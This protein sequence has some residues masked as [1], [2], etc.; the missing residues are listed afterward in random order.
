[1]SGSNSSLVRTSFNPSQQL[2][3]CVVA[4]PLV[5]CLSRLGEL[6]RLGDSLFYRADHVER[7]LREMV[8]VSGAQTF[9]PLDCV[10]NGD[11]FA[12]RAREDLRNVER[13]RQEA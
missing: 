3:N 2:P 1:M 6:L 7:L 11:E 4:I 9:E 5:S 13:L 12:G 8:V 10:L